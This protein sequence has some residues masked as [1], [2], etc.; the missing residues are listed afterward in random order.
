MTGSASPGMLNGFGFECV[1]WKSRS[2]KMP[3]RSACTTLRKRNGTAY[4]YVCILEP[5]LNTRTQHQCSSVQYTWAC[6]LDCV[7]AGVM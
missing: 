7:N 3:A 1:R 4:R 5:D 2:T 6:V